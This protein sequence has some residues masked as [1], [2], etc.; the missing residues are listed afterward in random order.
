M[1][2]LLSLMI[3]LCLMAMPLTG[4]AQEEK[5]VNILSWYGYIDDVTLTEFEEDTGI[6]VIWSP[7][8]SIDDMLTKM[9]Q[10][11]SGYDLIITSDYSLD[12]LRQ[13]GLLQKLDKSLLPNYENLNPQYLSQY[14]D[15]ENEYVIP[16]VAGCPLIIYDP[17]AVPF[18]I[19]SYEDL[20]RPELA[21]SVVVMDS[22]RIL[23]GITLKTMGYGMN[24]TDP[25][26]LKQAQEKMMSLYPNILAFG[27]LESVTAMETKEAS[28]G[29]MFTPFVYMV[30]SLYPDYQVVYPT[31]GLGYGIDGYVIPSNAENVENAHALLNYMMQPAIAARNAEAQMYMCVNQAA[32]GYLSSQ[33]VNDPVMNV[34]PELV[35]QAEFILNVGE[36]ETLYN[37]LYTTFK[38]Q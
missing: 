27:D 31:E 6:K 1:K 25:D 19:T 13:A 15:P 11:A 10:G 36:T 23:L 5:V 8:E 17:E 14:Y 2:K 34:D 38:L 29:F 32:T 18:E 16:H 3:A 22:A 35:A 26:L 30:K 24:E 28:V 20:W 12:I 4:L 37:E 9:T 21:D 7:M 33:Y